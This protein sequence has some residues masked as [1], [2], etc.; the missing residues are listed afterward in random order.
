MAKKTVRAAKPTQQRTKEEQWRKRMAA[1]ARTGATTYSAP[2][3]AGSAVAEPEDDV[4][5]Y[6]SA[7]VAPAA[8]APTPAPRA[9]AQRATSTPATSAA[10]ASAAQAA[11]RRNLASQRP[12]RPRA[13]ITNTMSVEEEMHYIRTDIRKLITLTAIC[14]VIIIILAFIVPSIVK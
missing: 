11:Q 12:V 3:G 5:T 14:I 13:G 7:A 8:V 4:E 1:Q 2:N 10:R 6:E 9:Q